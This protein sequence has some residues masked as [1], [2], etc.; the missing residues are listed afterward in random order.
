MKLLDEIHAGYVHRRR[1]WVL[2]DHLARLLPD[3][4]DVLDVGCGDGILTKLIAG[5]KPNVS[6]RGIDVLV[7]QQTAIPVSQFDG[8]VIPF[9]DASFEVVMLVDVLHHA[10]NPLVLL[11]EAERVSKKWILL[12][13]HTRDGWLARS[14]LRFMD[15]VG[16]RRHNVLLPHN[17]WPREHWLA[18]FRELDLSVDSWISDLGLYP[19]PANWIFDRSL[20]FV[21]RLDKGGGLPKSQFIF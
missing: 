15:L 13:D 1:V 12:K 4:G 11:R 9:A 8:T 14:T 19:L 3:S 18:A 6:I 21:A 10:T 5:K 20:H 7:R 17:Y 16:N 2:G